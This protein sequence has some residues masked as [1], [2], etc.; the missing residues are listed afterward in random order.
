MS[1]IRLKI[2]T[3]Q[4]VLATSF[5]GD[6]NSDVSHSYLPGSVV[7]GALIGRY[8]R[9]S[10]QREL[11]LTDPKV[12]TLFF[13]VQQSTYL[14]AYPVSQSGHRTLPI[15]RSWLKEK[16]TD[17]PLKAYDFSLEINDEIKAPKPVGNSFWGY[18]SKKQINLYQPSK[19]I[20]IHNARNRSK[21]RGTETEGEIF[22]Y[23][24]IDAGETFEGMI[25]CPSDHVSEI[26]KLLNPEDFWLGGSQSAGYGHVR[27]TYEILT[28]PWR[29][30]GIQPKVE[31]DGLQITLLSDVIL[32]DV[33]GQ[34]TANPDLLRQ[35][36]A[37][38][39]NVELT[40]HPKRR[41]YVGQTTIGGFNRKW[42]LPLPQ[43]PAL[44]M[45]SVLVLQGKLTPEQIQ[46][47]EMEGIGDRRIDGFGRLAINAWQE[48][49]IKIHK[50]YQPPPTS[51]IPVLAGETLS[52]TRTLAQRILHQRL[53]SELQK[54]ASE[55]S[56]E[57]RIS[58]SQLSRLR[59][60][61]RE[62]I[63]QGN[64]TD[65]TSSTALTSLLENLP[66]NARDQFNRAKVDG[67]SLMNW[68][69][70]TL[71]QPGAWITNP[72]ELTVRIANQTY[73]IDDSMKREYTLR[74]IMALA[75][76][77]TKMEE[78]V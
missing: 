51:Q 8:L 25:V 64:A 54:K 58:N 36:I 23:E 20:N 62:S 76:K 56:I 68:V 41:S 37:E 57:G 69:T 21:G 59:L 71:Q 30:A 63:N 9:Q 2:T 45:G 44:A 66:K 10:H 15:P 14:N 28:E 12:Q 26:E 52:M 72:D 29:E 65:S 32:R 67:R 39:F 13:D 60:I 33:M 48:E 7:R 55:L 47:L 74:L 24:A 61:A 35:A 42:G 6:P 49:E 16:G 1:I 43:M 34:V 5:D 19:R 18:D 46:Q 17:V 50:P 27:I 73:P 22:R 77:A 31:Y 3:V 53:E 40:F 78:S 38:K 4:P 70:E 75:R 11:D